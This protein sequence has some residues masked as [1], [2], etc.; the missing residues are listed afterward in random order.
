VV[1]DR[2]ATLSNRHACRRGSAS[3]RPTARPKDAR[4]GPP[5]PFY[6]AIKP[7]IAEK[8]KE[9]VESYEPFTAEELAAIFAPE[10]CAAYA[11]QPHFHWLPFLLL[12]TGARP[13]ELASLRLDQVRREP[14]IDYFA[15]KKAKNSKSIRKVPWWKAV[16]ESAFPANVTE[17]R[18][19]DPGGQLF[20]HGVA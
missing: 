14:G 9:S 8:A 16:R 1:Q 15:I 3:Q 12:H 17:Q 7:C 13:N 11:I 6:K 2:H 20:P 18:A 5:R 19:A 4:K 10:P